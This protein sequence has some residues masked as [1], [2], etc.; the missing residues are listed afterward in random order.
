MSGEK[1][2]TSWGSVILLC[3]ARRPLS[4]L[5]VSGRM[6]SHAAGGLKGQRP[7][8]YQEGSA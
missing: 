7:S 4:D 5:W 1:H 2:L 8:V 6:P 3:L